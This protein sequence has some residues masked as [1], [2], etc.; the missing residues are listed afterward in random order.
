MYKEFEAEYRT[1]G[2]PSPTYRGSKAFGINVDPN[3]NENEII[4]Q[5]KHRVQGLVAQAMCCDR[6]MVKIESITE[7]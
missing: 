2:Y 1:G 4:E 3:A 7:V 5:A 6:S